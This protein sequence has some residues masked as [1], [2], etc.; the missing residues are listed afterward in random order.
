VNTLI[1]STITANKGS[2]LRCTYGISVDEYEAMLRK[3]DNRCAICRRV[4]GTDKN[5]KPHLDHDHSSGWVREIVCNT[6]NFGLGHFEDD[7]ERLQRAVEYLIS[8]ATPTEF[9]ISAARN[10]SKI[11]ANDPRKFSPEERERR[12]T[13]MLGNNFKQG[14]PAWNKGIPGWLGPKQVIFSGPHSEE[15][16]KKMSAARMGNKYSL[17]RTH[18][19]ETRRRM[20]ESHRARLAAAKEAA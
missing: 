8:N 19:E 20:S 13:L 12:R 15:S 2:R 11:R 5:T 10:A 14:V 1:P 3:Q 4:F 17:G 6:C 9:N 7:I 18:S 16:K